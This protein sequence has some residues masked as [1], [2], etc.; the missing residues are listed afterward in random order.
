M[1]FFRSESAVIVQGG[2][3]RLKR[4]F[5]RWKHAKKADAPV[6]G[7]PGGRRRPGD[8][9]RD[10]GEPGETARAAAPTSRPLAQQRCRSVP[11][12][13]ARAAGDT[14]EFDRAAAPP[15]C[16]GTRPAS[17]ETRARPIARPRRRR[18]R[19]T[20]PA[21]GRRCDETLAWP[22]RSRG[23][24]ARAAALPL[25]PGDPPVDAVATR[26]SRGRDA[27]RRLR[28]RTRRPRGRDALTKNGSKATE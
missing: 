19:E 18:D 27:T 25:R 14:G 3:Q 1:R 13:A 16:P 23:R 2:Q 6:D 17:Q 21:R 26:R 15:L 10:A 12:D 28:G 9:A 5:L 7:Y 8:A 4:H 22:P 20:A 24:D 11:G